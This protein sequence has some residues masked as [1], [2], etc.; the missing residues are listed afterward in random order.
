[1]VKLF[2]GF[3][4]RCPS[5]TGDP[6]FW[7]DLEDGTNIEALLTRLG[8]QEEDPKEIIRN[9]RIGKLD[10]VLQDGDVVA[11]FSPLAGGG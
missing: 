11:I 9:H 4:D 2:G 10:H 8:I 7:V 5:V 6:Y 1:M 3:R